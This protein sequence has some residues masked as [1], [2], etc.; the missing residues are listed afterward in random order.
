M[1][2]PA[3]T[4]TRYNIFINFMSTKMRKHFYT[5]LQ[6]DN[7]KENNLP[8]KGPKLACK[9]TEEEECER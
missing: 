7:L 2:S 5:F 3:D 6:R 4:Q 1:T 9:S 8:A